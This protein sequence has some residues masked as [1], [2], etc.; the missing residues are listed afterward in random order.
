MANKLD[1]T[2]GDGPDEQGGD[3][4]DTKKVDDKQSDEPKDTSSSAD[5]SSGDSTSKDDTG[6]KGGDDDWEARFKGLQPK[7]QTAVETHKV[8]KIAWDADR[9]KLL[10][11]VSDGETKLKSA[12]D[13]VSKLTETAETTGKGSE[14][15]QTQ[16]DTLGKQVERDKLIM[17]EYPDLALYESKGLLPKDLD[18]DELKT[19]LNEFRVIQGGAAL[20]ALKALGAGE[21]GDEELITGDRSKGSDVASLQDQLMKAN[22]AGDP[23]EIKRLTDLLVAEQNKVF[24]ADAR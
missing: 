11:Q 13:E 5:K 21:T 22:V 17:A 1:E 16:I 15:M 14:E 7:Y 24:A 12:Q 9:I 2:A 3:D 19:A 23:K 18:G 4:K 20:D 10:G 6:D 8:D